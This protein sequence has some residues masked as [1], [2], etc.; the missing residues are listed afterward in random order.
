MASLA[1]AI[2][3]ALTGCLTQRDAEDAT[4]KL[5]ATR[6]G[7]GNY[8]LDLR[9]TLLEDEVVWAVI[10]PSSDG[11]LIEF[12]GELVLGEAANGPNEGCGYLWTE[13][14]SSWFSWSGNRASFE[15]SFLP[16]AG[17]PLM[18]AVTGVSTRATLRSTDMSTLP[19]VLAVEGAGKAAAE[20]WIEHQSLRSNGPFSV[21]LQGTGSIHCPKDITDFGAASYFRTPTHQEARD[22][23]L[24]WQEDLPS[25]TIL[26]YDTTG[27][28][29]L[30]VVFGDAKEWSSEASNEVP[31]NFVAPPGTTGIRLHQFSGDGNADIYA[32]HV[33]LPP[34]FYAKALRNATIALGQNPNT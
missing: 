17:P 33:T 11:Q 29:D 23:M 25:V 6:D 32:I 20:D 24:V 34:D 28:A 22:G 9:P 19:I 3:L 12:T 10:E 21:H 26:S 4:L 15:G 8:N 5:S 1:L 31:V 27:T 18:D 13:R 14:G 16:T 30:E 7:D 2:I